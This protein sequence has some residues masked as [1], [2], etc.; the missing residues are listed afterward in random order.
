MLKNRVRRLRR[1]RDPLSGVRGRRRVKFII[2]RT[3]DNFWFGRKQ[4]N[5]W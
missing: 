2:E 1:G 4:P 3:P 5:R